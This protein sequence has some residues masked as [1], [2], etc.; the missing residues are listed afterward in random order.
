MTTWRERLAGLVAIDPRSLALVRVGLALIVLVDAGRCWIDADAFF[1][2]DGLQPIAVCRQYLSS[3]YCWSMHFLGESTSFHRAIIS[4]AALSAAALC[5]GWKTRLATIICWA[6]TLSVAH[7]CPL[8]VNGGDVLVRVLL[9][10]GMFLPLGRRWSLDARRAGRTSHRAGS[11]RSVAS[12]ALLIQVAA[13]YAVAGIV[14]INEE[15]LS[16]RAVEYALRWD[17]YGRPL[18]RALL[19]FPVVLPWLTWATL[20]LELA[21]PALLFWPWRTWQVRIVTVSALAIF[22][23]GLAATMTLGFFP[24]ASVVALCAFLPSRFWDSLVLAAEPGMPRWS[25]SASSRSAARTP[26]ETHAATRHVGRRVANAATSVCCGF[27]L[28]YV[29]FYNLATLPFES[30]RGLM[31]PSLRTIGHLTGTRQRWALFDRPSKADGW[32]VANA[33]LVDGRRVDI[34]R[35]GRVVTARKPRDISEIFPNHRWRH[36]FRY[37]TCSV[38]DAFRQEAAEFLVHRWNGR[39]GADEQI[40]SC[41]LVFHSEPTS[42]DVRPG[43]YVSRV[44]ARVERG[45]ESLHGNFA[46]ALDELRLGR[47]RGY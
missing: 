14:K 39:H 13:V 37:L 30:C 19:E 9:F 7:R 26:G 24:Y 23:L 36:H 12:A 45:D 43:D 21:A 4:V 1:A 16:G 33:R 28:A 17:Q 35:N 10:W 20:G 29:M 47:V 32:F 3:P 15:W 8:A 27:F 40:V 18:G 46:E 2:D 25:H 6:W 42:E 11:I 22:H 34:L 38:P 44:L 31:S 41:D 5:L